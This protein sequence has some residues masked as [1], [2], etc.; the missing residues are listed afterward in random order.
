M[1]TV[2]TEDVTDWG[3]TFAIN[4]R[5]PLTG[6]LTTYDLIEDGENINVTEVLDGHYLRDR[7]FEFGVLNQFSYFCR[8]DDQRPSNELK[9]L[10][11][12]IWA[13]LYTFY[14]SILEP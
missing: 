13:T 14:S 1:E 3:L 9:P 11:H 5:D 2:L 6:E 12:Y 4:E 8:S 7:N 10:G